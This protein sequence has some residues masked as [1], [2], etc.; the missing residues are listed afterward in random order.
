MGEY[1]NEDVNKWIN[2]DMRL[3]ECIVYE[4]VN[5]FFLFW[6]FVGIMRIC[7]ILYN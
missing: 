5:L 1:K 6:I 2:W 3:Y 7:T 4:D